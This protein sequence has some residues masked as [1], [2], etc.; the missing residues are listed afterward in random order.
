MKRLFILVAAVITLMIVSVGIASA[1]PAE[2]S[3]VDVPGAHG[4]G[5]DRR[6]ALLL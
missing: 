4:L 5:S 2:K 3:D 6:H 1:A